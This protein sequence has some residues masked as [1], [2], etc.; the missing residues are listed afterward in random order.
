MKRAHHMPFGTEMLSEG[1]RFRLWAPGAERVDLCLEGGVPLP[2]QAQDAGWYQLDTTQ[3]SPGSRYRFR[4]DGEMEV[5]DPVSR[6]NPDDV[7]GHSEVVDPAGFAWRDQDWRGRPWED[8]VVY[9]L[10]VGS[11]SPEGTFAGVEARLDAL[12]ELG[13]TAIEL[14]PVAGFPGRR[15]WGYD[16]VLHYAP[17]SSYGSP[18]ELKQLVQSA[19]N[20][21]LMVFLDVVYNHFGPEG[22]YLHVY[23]PQFFTDRHQTPWGAGINFD[24]PDSRPV[25]EFFIHNALYWLE[26]YHFDGLRL[27]AV[28]AI[29]DDSEQHILVELVQAVRTGPGRERHVHLVLENDDNIADYLRQG[30][31]GQ[32]NDDIHHVYHVLLTGEQDGYYQDYADN[33]RQMLGRCLTEGFAYQGEPSPYRNNTP[34]GERSAD[35]PVSRFVAFIQNHD[36]V[37]N[38]AFGER[39]SELAAPAALRAMSAVYLLAPSPPLLFM[40]EEWATRQR[41]PFFCDF[42]P[43]LA[44]AVTE[45]RRREFAAFD[46]F[47]GAQA[48]ET[49][50]DPNAP[51]T[52]E[53][54][55]LDWD[56]RSRQDDWLR[57]YQ[58]LLRLRAQVLVP[59]LKD[60]PAEGGDFELLGTQGLQVSWRLGDGSRYHLSANLSDQPLAFRLPDGKQLYAT[61]GLGDDTLGPW[62][63]VW[64]LEDRH[65]R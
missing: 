17:T 48:L 22:N 52:F 4:I 9:E 47:Q 5:P 29:L 7:H 41:F 26:E 42:G 20:R 55:R 64:Q 56:E 60:L 63:V 44:Q 16:G 58:A 40:G 39:L 43:E 15:N 13:V 19:H 3:A 59:R 36:Q 10:H 61:P 18:D 32:W 65:V 21:G 46:R 31:D 54:A 34:R 6:Y 35:L 23:A 27:D 28:H 53:A 51:E 49:I 11:F 50:P 38:R 37:G 2:M 25:R 30:Y 62:T 14:M 33:P 12:V 24:G 1:V 8:V 45:G 57:H